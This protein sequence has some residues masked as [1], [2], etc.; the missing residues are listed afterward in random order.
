VKKCKLQYRFS[1]YYTVNE[2]KY[3]LVFLVFSIQANVVELSDETNEQC[4]KA[5]EANEEH[6]YSI[7]SCF[8]IQ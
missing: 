4:K 2:I 6:F 8:I 1:L 7:F 3:L 5:A